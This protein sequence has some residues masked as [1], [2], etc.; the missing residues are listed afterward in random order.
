[1]E[2]EHCENA[3]PW[4]IDPQNTRRG[5][6]WDAGM[7]GM[8]LTA[9]DTLIAIHEGEK[10][11]HQDDN[12]RIDIVI[13][14]SFDQGLTWQPWQLVHTESNQTHQVTIGQGTPVLDHNTGRLWMLLTRNN[15]ELLLTYTDDHGASWAKPSDITAATKPAGYGWIA[16]SFSGTQLR[17]GRLA[18][19]ADHIVD[20]WTAYPITHTISSLITSDDHGA[21]WQWQPKGSPDGYEMNEC[22]IASLPNGTVVMNARNYLGQANHSVKRALMWSHDEGVSWSAPYL[23]P[24]LPDPIVQGSMVAGSHTPLGL[25][26]GQPLFFTNAH[27]EWD[28]ANDTLMMSTTG[29]AT[30]QPL[31]R[32]QHGCSEYTGLVQFKDGRIGA[33]FDDGGPFPAGYKPGRN[34]CKMMTNNETFVLVELTPS[35]PE[36]DGAIAPPSPFQI[37]LNHR[38]VLSGSQ[39]K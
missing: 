31:L 15:S 20:Q 32:L 38:K 29:G 7:C 26:V 9:N 3:I 17:S 36:A 11:G 24:D 39:I 16:P 22:A 37:K 23:N 30:W 6:Y 2:E 18:V 34:Q 8:V 25:G 12:N 35:P 14:R 28:R 1:M 33:G 10:Y 13:R 19:C 27:S 21:T 4:S 5:Y